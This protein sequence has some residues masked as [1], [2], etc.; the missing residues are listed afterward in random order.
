[1]KNASAFAVI[2]LAF[3]ALG[4]V[5][6]AQPAQ[7]PGPE[8]QRNPIEQA[9]YPPELIASH[10]Q[11]LGL[12]DEQRDFIRGEMQAAQAQ[13][14]GLEWDLKAEMGALVD[15]IARSPVDEER[16]LA[17]LDRVMAVE[18]QIKK[19]RLQLDI[20]IKNTLDPEQ[21]R[22]LDELREGRR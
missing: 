16:A 7:P 4:P 2:T 3:W 18:S 15:I 6:D 13:F 5:A 10:Q 22:Q 19:M 14:T 12:T 11:A 8:G 9:F 21:C 1:M 17:Q 20:R